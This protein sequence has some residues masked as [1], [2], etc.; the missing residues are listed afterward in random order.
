MAIAPRCVRVVLNIRGLGILEKGVSNRTKE[1]CFFCEAGK[2]TAAKQHG[3]GLK[4]LSRN[5]LVVPVQTIH[6]KVPPK[7]G[8]F[9]CSA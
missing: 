9:H 8:R 5:V 4:K 3:Q 7:L 1:L 6:Q 2:L